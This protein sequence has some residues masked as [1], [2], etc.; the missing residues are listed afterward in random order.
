M[1]EAERI[2]SALESVQITADPEEVSRKVLEVILSSTEYKGG[3]LYLE[4]VDLTA[5][6]GVPR[7]KADKLKESIRSEMAGPLERGEISFLWW[8]DRA[9]RIAVVP[10]SSGGRRIGFLCLEAGAEGTTQTPEMLKALGEAIGDKL[11]ASLSLKG[12]KGG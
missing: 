8:L 7:R 4:P 10:I 11:K 12:N 3:F 5:Y 2:L 6:A 1:K 9:R